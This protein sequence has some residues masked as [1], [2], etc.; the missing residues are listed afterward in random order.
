MKRLLPV[1]LGVLALAFAVP[2]V[3]DP[4]TAHSFEVVFDD[5]NPCTGDTMTVT[6]AVTAFV[7]IHDSRMVARSERTITTSDGSVGHGT[8]SFVANGQIV[9]DRFTDIMTNTSGGYHFRAR[10]LF[11]LDV[12][13]ATVRVDGFELTCL[14]PA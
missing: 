9:K 1:L 5:V 4:P 11:V 8:T 10:G 3:A 2:A 12:S 7:H 13:T 14:G 6:I